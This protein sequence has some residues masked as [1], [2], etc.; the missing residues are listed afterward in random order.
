MFCWTGI[1]FSTEGLEA[2]FT[3]NQPLTAAKGGHITV[4]KAVSGR[5]R[6]PPNGSARPGWVHRWVHERALH[7][8]HLHRRRPRGCSRRRNGDSVT[9]CTGTPFER[10]ARPTSHCS[11]QQ[12]RTPLLATA[13]SRLSGGSLRAPRARW[14]AYEDGSSIQASGLRVRSRM[15]DLWDMPRSFRRT[16]T[17]VLSTIRPWRTCSICT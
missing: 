4:V 12:W 3:R 9:A 17:F 11:R 5:F 8:G 14:S 2:A 16:A 6:T 15:R 7:S 13:L 10:L 1:R